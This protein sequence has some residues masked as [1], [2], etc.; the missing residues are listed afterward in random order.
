[1][2]SLSPYQSPV[3]TG[4]SA[5]QTE[6]PSKAKLWMRAIWASVAMIIVPPMLGLVGTVIGMVGAF[7][8]LKNSGGADPKALAGD[9]SVALLTTFYGLIFSIVGLIL[10]IVSFVRYRSCRTKTQSITR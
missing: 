7:G 1:M 10:L 5:I 3:T 8:E 9:I 4:E 6:L 2:S